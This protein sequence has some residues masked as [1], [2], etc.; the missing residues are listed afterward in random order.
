MPSCPNA[1]SGDCSGDG[2]V[3]MDFVRVFGDR[4]CLACSQRGN[5][6]ETGVPDDLKPGATVPEPGNDD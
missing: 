6:A 3:S 2:F 5:T 1:A 4:P